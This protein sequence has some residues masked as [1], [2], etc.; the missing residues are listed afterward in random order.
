MFNGVPQGSVLGPILFIIYINDLSNGINNLSKFYADDSK[1]IAKI[2]NS[3]D[4]SNLQRD[5]NSVIEWCNKWIMQL[6]VNKCK[7]VHIG[8][9]QSPFDYVIP[10]SSGDFWTLETTTVERD[11]GIMLSCDMKWH[12]QVVLAAYKANQILGMIKQ[13]F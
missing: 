12:N 3:D 4:T 6:N 10:V 8:S 7:I 5:I 11:L 1:I 2:N 13:T 9:H